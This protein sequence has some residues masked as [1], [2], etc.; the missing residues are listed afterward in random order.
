MEHARPVELIL[1]GNQPFAARALCASARCV[2]SLGTECKLGQS[3]D[4]KYRNMQKQSH[5]WFYRQAG[6]QT[7]SGGKEIKCYAKNLLQTF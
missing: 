5:I 2:R 3:F 7:G 4:W 1:K 6:R